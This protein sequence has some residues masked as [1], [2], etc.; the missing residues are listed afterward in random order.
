MG[1]PEEVRKKWDEESLKKRWLRISKNGKN[2]QP[3]ISLKISEN[4]PIPEQVKLRQTD[5]VQTPASNTGE[6][7]P[8]RKGRPSPRTGPRLRTPGHLL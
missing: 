2:N 6:R 8:E 4:Q 5:L 7:Q 1:S 3:T